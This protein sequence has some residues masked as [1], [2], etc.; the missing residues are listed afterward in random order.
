MKKNSNFKTVMLYA[1][2]LYEGAEQGGFLEKTYSDARK[3]L[4]AV[5]ASGEQLKQLDNPLWT[6][7]QKSELVFAVLKNLEL[8]TSLTNLIKLLIE[9]RRISDLTNVLQ[10]FILLYNDRHDIA[11]VEVATVVPLNETQEKSL[12]EKL[13]GIF[14]K[15]IELSFVI[16]PEIIGG[17]IIRYKSNLIDVSVRHKLDA[18]EQLM[19]GTK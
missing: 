12:K 4:R 18:L 5:A 14:K 15:H 3:L 1:E 6:D 2:S 16:E 9:N 7:E 17:L 11:E 10:R 8:C 19:K 13:N